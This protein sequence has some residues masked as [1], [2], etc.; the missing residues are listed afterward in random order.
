MKNLKLLLK[1]VVILP[2][3]LETVQA[4][5][6]T[7]I[8]GTG[9]TT[10][11][12]ATLTVTNPTSQPVLFKLGLG[13]I[14]SK[15]FET[16]EGPKKSQPQIHT[17]NIEQEIAPGETTEIPVEGY[18]LDVGKP[19]LPAGEPFP[20]ID[21]WV[22]PASTS[23]E[24]VIPGL[25]EAFLDNLPASFKPI[26]DEGATQPADELNPAEGE[27]ENQWR[28]T[29]PGTEE[30]FDFTIDISEHPEDAAQILFPMVENI[31]TTYHELQ[32]NGEIETP[33][34]NDENR[35]QKSVIQQLTWM[36]TSLLQGQK[37][38]KEEFAGRMEDPE[39]RLWRRPP[40]ALHGDSLGR[41]G[42]GVQ[43]HGYPQHHGLHGLP[44][45]GGTNSATRAT[46]ATG[47]RD[48]PNAEHD[49]EA[50]RGRAGGTGRRSSEHRPQRAMGRSSRCGGT[51]RRVAPLH[52]R[53]LHPDGANV[54]A[55]RAEDS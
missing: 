51:H 9:R 38:G 10:G 26:K 28:L 3:L 34:L 14:P 27:N 55:D 17:G 12:I 20:P 13:I 22:S 44:Q 16:D 2:L 54:V 18:C 32:Q 31:T 29:I 47:A 5:K 21:E 41:R 35:Q 48:A 52:A 7:R 43:E 33:F 4:Q 46:L 30:P 40:G 37:Y 49:E 15:E 50:N 36:A 39:G 6:V 1:L 45:G 42:H 11:H 25:S 53:G 24:Q 19:P 8:I 23:P